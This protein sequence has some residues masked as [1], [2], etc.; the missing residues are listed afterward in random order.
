MYGTEVKI[1]HNKLQKEKLSYKSDDIEIFINGSID[2][3]DL[4][5]N[6][7]LIMDYK[8]GRADSSLN[9][10][11][12]GRKIQLYMY[13]SA[14]TQGGEIKHGGVFY[15]PISATYDKYTSKT[16]CLFQG[17]V[18]K[19]ILMEIDCNYEDNKKGGGII[20]VTLKNDGEINKHS[21]NTAID[22]EIME[23]ICR[24]ALKL[25]YRAI[26]EIL[27][28]YIECKPCIGSCKYC[29]IANGCPYVKGISID[30]EESLS[31]DAE[32]FRGKN[33]W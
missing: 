32:S 19:G 21:S 8:T 12:Y 23:N 22:Q 29:F 16:K 9:K 3:I 25:S 5:N 30:R 4:Y 6:Y 15:V 18:N 33:L 11:Y 27:D 13:M 17:Q 10:V 20:D 14:L 24:Y 31:V 26:Q 2:R 1:N 28:G 7:A